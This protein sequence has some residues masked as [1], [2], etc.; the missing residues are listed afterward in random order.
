MHFRLRLTC[1]LLFA[2]AL[3][4]ATV[5][6]AAAQGFFSP[7][8]PMQSNRSLHTATT[9]TDGSVLVAGGHD[10]QHVF[11]SLSSAEVFDPSTGTFSF[12]SNTMQIGRAQHTA[13]V[14]T[15]G[16]VL[17]T[18]GENQAC[19][20]N[21]GSFGSRPNDTAD[22]YDPETRTFTA[23]A[24]RMSSIRYSHAATR[25]A[26]GRV[27]I[28]G[29]I[30]D[31]NLVSFTFTNS[32]DIYDPA[33]NSFT[34]TGSMTIARH[35]HASV[36]LPDGKVLIVGGSQSGSTAELFD[37]AT[38]T[39]TP[40]AHPPT[41]STRTPRAFALSDGTVVLFGHDKQVQKY[42]PASQT[43]TQMPSSIYEHAFWSAVVKLSDEKVLLADNFA[44]EIYN[45]FTGVS[46]DAGNPLVGDL[47]PAG[48]ALADGRALLTGGEN[49]VPFTFVAQN[50][51][52]V[53]EPN[54]APVASAGPD[55]QISAGAGCAATVSLDGSGSN[56][57]DG[58]TLTYRWSIGATPLGTGVTLSTT[59]GAGTH[60]ITLTVSDTA[61]E[62]SSDTTSVVVAD[63]TP[64]A[65]TVNA[66]ITLEQSGP[67]GTPFTLPAPVVTDNCSASPVVTVSGLPANGVFPPGDTTIIY[68]ATDAAANQATATTTVT[69]RDTVPPVIVSVQ[70]SV[71][72][73]WPVNHKMVRVT[74]AITATDAA[75]P[76]CSVTGVTS[77]EASNS[78]EPDWSI[79]GP[80]Q[81]QLRAERFGNGPGR[82][83]TLQVRCLDASGNASTASTTV[84]VRHDQGR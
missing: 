18:G 65:I 72:T 79:D 57:P 26:D 9:L 4:L 73:L 50:V 60:V 10:R 20:T 36:L 70:P 43:F 6:P 54:A 81:V 78:H 39:F 83:Y 15:S 23:T 12:T 56:D 69:V 66:S 19:C 59:L 82:V 40:T 29:G 27:L 71:T 13:T 14:L 21:T 80:L 17:L 25:L 68:T 84:N 8:G 48:A 67:A 46:A 31:I 52:S 2:P 37:P 45:P 75:P 61:G 44:A 47:F 55:Q 24:N 16:K 35:A 77:S 7:V 3:A 5:R 22:V 76:A 63:T 32:A 62:T 41:P 64:P 30:T 51:A 49:F 58:D 38:G 11:E 53:L 74:L 33:T 28:T 1:V 42:D 34:P